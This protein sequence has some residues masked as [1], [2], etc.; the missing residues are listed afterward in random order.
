MAATAWETTPITTVTTGEQLRGALLR[1]GLKPTDSCL[2]H[3]RL[4]A[5]GFIPGGVQTLVSMLKDVLCDGDIVMPAQTADI[6]DP[7]DWDAPPVEPSLVATVH[8]ALPPYDPDTTPVTGIGVTPEYFRSLPGTRRSGHPTCSMSAWGRHADWIADCH[9]DGDYDMPFGDRSPLAKLVELDGTV[10]FLGT[11]FGTCTAL[12]Y[13]ESTIGRPRIRETAPV[14]RVDPA[15]GKRKT[16]WAGYANVELEPYDDFE[17]F[18]ETFLAEHANEVRTVELNGGA[19]R[20][21]PIRA[22][23][24]AARAYWR[25]ADAE[26]KK[27]A[28]AAKLN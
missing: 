20:A 11:G 17:R 16:E 15:T 12:H 18:G 14:L 6:T 5:F 7:A 22:L 9:R 24:E 19:I 13:A 4:S 26:R 23:V 1:V 25:A 27:T 10:V 21:F 3:T 28:A 2:V 8:D